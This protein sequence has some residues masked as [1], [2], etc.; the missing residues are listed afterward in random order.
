MKAPEPLADVNASENPDLGIRAGTTIGASLAAMKE[1]GGGRMKGFRGVSLKSAVA[2]VKG[3]RLHT[4]TRTAIGVD[5]GSR[6]VKAVQFGRERWGDGVWR[7]VAVAEMPRSETGHAAPP[8][9][10]GAGTN[11]GAA[12]AAA[13]VHVLKPAEVARLAGTLERQGFVGSDVVLAVP[14]DKLATSVLDLPPRSS[15]APLE[16]IARMELARAHRCAPDSFEMGSWDLPAAARA[17]KATPVMAVACSHADATA[18]IDPFE[19]EGLNVRAL[20]V[21]A[22][23]LARACQSLL[24]PAGTITAMLD[25]GWS[26]ANLSLLH[27]GVVIYAR[28]L[29]DGGVCKLYQTLR[30]RL[31][32]DAEVIDYLLAES[33]LGDAGS[34][35]SPAQRKPPADAAG[36][37]AAHFEAAVQE[38]KV[39]LQ[40]ARHQ[41]PETSVSRLLVAGGGACIRGV[42]SHLS[43]AMGIEARTAAP[44]DVAQWTAAVA[45]AC[46]SPALTLA[47]GLSQFPEGGML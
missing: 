43:R 23:A 47:V 32:L 18:L 44:S 27:Q 46:E 35:Q 20:D 33:G 22:C 37:I 21:R 34:T 17:A 3:K 31:N 24:G 26:A 5:V 11:G 45:A 36:L 30:A 41:Y 7:I 15:Q 8:T 25:V 1:A 28:S 29:P 40:Y 2:A 6:T 4:Q 13:N 16:Q 10:T 38:L 9:A 12:S 42:A 14:T 39:S 19:A